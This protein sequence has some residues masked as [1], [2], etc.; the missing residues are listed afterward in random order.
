MDE[1]VRGG[2]GRG[3]GGGEKREKGNVGREKHT[4]L[5]IEPLLF[6]WKRR[7]KKKIAKERE[8]KD[9]IDFKK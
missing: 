7:K 1:K 3:G 2:G 5:G 6:Y 9:K 8:K 4:Q